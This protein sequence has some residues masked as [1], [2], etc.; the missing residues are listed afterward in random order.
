[1]IIGR[2]VGMLGANGYLINYIVVLWFIVVLQAIRQLAVDTLWHHSSKRYHASVKVNIF[3][4]TLLRASKIFM[5]FGMMKTLNLFTL[6]KLLQ[7]LRKKARRFYR[8]NIL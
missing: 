3:T 1:M 6:I 5:L 8:Q 7:I 4:G 2:S